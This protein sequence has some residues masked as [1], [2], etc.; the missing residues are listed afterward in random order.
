MIGLGLLIVLILYAYLTK[1]TVRFVGTR[2]KSKLAKYVTL[3]VFILIPTW[4]IIPG[5]LYFH[6]LCQTEAGVKVY[7]TMEI[8]QSYFTVDGK[9]DIKKLEEKYAQPDRLDRNFSSIFHIAKSESAILDKQTGDVLGVATDF[10]YRGSWISTHIL[11]DRG[12]T[13]CPAYPHSLVHNVIWGE[14]FKSKPGSSS[15]VRE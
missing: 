14:V 2:T 11:V 3:A 1:T 4:D 13:S 6:R 5:R 7:K 12:G 8:N 10:L 15:K 9:P